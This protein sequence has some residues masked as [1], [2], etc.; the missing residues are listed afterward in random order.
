MKDREIYDTLRRMLGPLLI[1]H[2]FTSEGSRQATF[3]RRVSDELFHAISCDLFAHRKAFDVI[4]CPCSPRFGSWENFP[5]GLLVVSGSR[6]RLNVTAGVGSGASRFS[7]ASPGALESSITKALL[8]ALAEFA[9]PYLE[10]FQAL[11]DIVPVLEHAQW[12]SLLEA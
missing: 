8:P 3:H 5:D 7:C 10:Q 6:G 11:R 2:G 4:V 12:A 9:L 1:S